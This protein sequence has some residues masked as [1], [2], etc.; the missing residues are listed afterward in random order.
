MIT[1]ANAE[2]PLCSTAAFS[3]DT[4]IFDG[5]KIETDFITNPRWDRV[6]PI[7]EEGQ[8]FMCRRMDALLASFPKQSLMLDVGTGSGVFAIWAAKRGHRVIGIDINPRALQMARQ[9][10]INNGIE[11]FD[12]PEDLTRRGI[13]L[14]LKRFHERFVTKIVFQKKF[15]CVFLNPPYNPTCPGITPALHAE[16]GKDGQRCFREQIALVPFILKDDGVC[17]GIQMTVKDR[18]GINAINEIEKAFGERCSLSY[19][20]IFEQ[21]YFSVREFLERQ[22]ETYLSA[23][24]SAVPSA[25]VNRY[26]EEVSSGDPEF[27]FIYYNISKL[28]SLA[29]ERLPVMPLPKTSAP[30]RNWMNRIELHKQI[31]DNTAPTRIYDS[32]LGYNSQNNDRAWREPERMFESLGAR[33][34]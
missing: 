3:T 33:L 28:N 23:K 31:V 4:V 21:N 25:E 11:V 9:N 19:A 24:V 32:E 30:R 8:I 13:C 29:R 7:F 10:A 26:I 22:Y 20:H 5:L 1:E 18:R 16:S 15:D 12:R 6:M 2:P 17:V 34:F 27:A 14:I